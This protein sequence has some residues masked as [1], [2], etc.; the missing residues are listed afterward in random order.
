MMTLSTLMLMLTSQV[1]EVGVGT[2]ALYLSVKNSKRI[3]FFVHVP[4]F[5]MTLWSQFLIMHDIREE[6]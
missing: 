6:N 4:F 1:P 5:V 2:Y 3:D